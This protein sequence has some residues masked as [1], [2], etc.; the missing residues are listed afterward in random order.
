MAEM[1][2]VRDMSGVYKSRDTRRITP[3]PMNVASTK[4]NSIDQ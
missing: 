2:F 4:T 3:N 1:A